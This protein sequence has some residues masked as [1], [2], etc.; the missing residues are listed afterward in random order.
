MSEIKEEKN[1]HKAQTNTSTP[2]SSRMRPVINLLL[3]ESV[4]LSEI[5][6]RIGISR[7]TV[8]RW[9]AADDTRLSY[10]EELGKSLGYHLEWRFV[11][12]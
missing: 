10:L 2:T 4:S 6:E 3:N 1:M 5:A 7:A 9:L 8:S 11:K 12:D